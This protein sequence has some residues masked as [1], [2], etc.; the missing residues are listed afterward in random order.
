M[1]DEQKKSEISNA[2]KSRTVWVGILL[3]AIQVVSVLPIPQ[4]AIIQAIL[5]AIATVLGADKLKD[6]LP[7]TKSTETKPE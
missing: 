5:G 6:V 3:G 2:L 7:S 1:A 4:V